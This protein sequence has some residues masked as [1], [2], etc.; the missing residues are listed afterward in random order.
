MRATLTVLGEWTSHDGIDA[1]DWCQANVAIG[2]KFW[3]KVRTSGYPS[4]R[5]HTRPLHSTCS[6]HRTRQLAGAKP[7]LQVLVP[8]VSGFHRVPL[9][10]APG[11][12]APIFHLLGEVE[13]MKPGLLRCLGGTPPPPAQ[14]PRA[15]PSRCYLPKSLRRGFAVLAF[16]WWL[17]AEVCTSCPSC[18]PSGQQRTFSLW[19]SPSGRGDHLA[20]AAVGATAFVP[21]R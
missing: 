14:P 11:P 1:A 12:S 16:V 3:F 9:P 7:G 13:L 19:A 15:T 17:L 18:P 10:L 20:V 2:T 8:D 21:A 4:T 6:T 5:T